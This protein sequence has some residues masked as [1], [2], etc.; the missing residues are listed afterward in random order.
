ML[1]RQKKK[2]NADGLFSQQKLLGNTNLK[3][4]V[5]IRGFSLITVQQDRL[6]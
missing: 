6:Q 2:K 4:K 1:Q 3:Q 5:A